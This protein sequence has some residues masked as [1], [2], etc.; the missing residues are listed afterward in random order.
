MDTN[1]VERVDFNALGGTDDI[2]VNDLS[3]PMSAEWT[4]IS[5]PCSGRSAVTARSDRIIVKGSRRDD[6]IDVAGDAAAISVTGLA[7]TTTIRDPNP[8]TS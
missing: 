6:D 3:G 1:D 7:A 2:N 8:P 5:P 4:S